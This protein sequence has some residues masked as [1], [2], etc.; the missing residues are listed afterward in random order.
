VGSKAALRNLAQLAC[1][2]AASARLDLSPEQLGSVGRPELPGDT[3]PTYARS[4]TSAHGSSAGLKWA[5]SCPAP[6]RL[7]RP[8]RDLCVALGRRAGRVPGGR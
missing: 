3:S 7:S 6:L 5:R 4:A 1:W 2:A 8:R